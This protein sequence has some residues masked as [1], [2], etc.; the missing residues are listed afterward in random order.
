LSTD[1]RICKMLAIMYEDLR[2]A[3]SVRVQRSR[4][5]IAIIVVG[6]LPICATA[7]SA[8]ADSASGNTTS[9]S[10]SRVML[11]DIRSYV[12]APLHWDG[13]DWAY[14][15]GAAAAVMLSHHYDGQIRTHFTRGSITAL[16]G[17]DNRE[18][19]DAI[20]AVALLTGTWLYANLFEDQ[21][22]RT[23]SRNM[24]EAA[25]LSAA[26]TLVLRYAVGRQRPNQTVDPDVWHS[27]G[28]SFPSLHATVA[29][30]IGTVFAESGTD[31][32]I[33]LTRIVG[34][35]IAAGSGY[36]RLKHNAHWLSDTVMGAAVGMATAHFVVNREDGSKRSAA[37]LLLP[38]DHGGLLTFNMTLPRQ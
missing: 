5:A 23:V 31:K 36:S 17:T 18:L 19:Q 3:A 2:A 9:D 16:D 10:R 7:Q 6:L 33:W 24:V 28:S 25:G 20:P 37:V 35:G 30:A 12:S 29:F 26:T 21:A 1:V 38:M 32:S 14:F 27:G 15:G 22:G 13:G 34:Y 8:H 4:R 11:E